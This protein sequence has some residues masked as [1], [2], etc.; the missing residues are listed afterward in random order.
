[1]KCLLGNLL[2]YFHLRK[3]K[4]QRDKVNGLGPTSVR[5][6]NQKQV[7]GCYRIFFLWKVPSFFLFPNNV[8]SFLFIFFYSSMYFIPRHSHTLKTCL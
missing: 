7:Y 3:K 2:F 4:N 5:E 8:S 6:W 1:M